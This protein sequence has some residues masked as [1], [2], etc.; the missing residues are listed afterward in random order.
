VGV[1]TTAGAGVDLV[2]A[3]DAEVRNAVLEA[4]DFT[5]D[6]QWIMMWIVV[7]KGNQGYTSTW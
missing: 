6:H 1:V 2:G 4:I 7:K 3:D 5:S